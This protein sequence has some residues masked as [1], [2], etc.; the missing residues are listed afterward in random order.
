MSFFEQRIAHD[1]EAVAVAI[2][3]EPHALDRLAAL[4]RRAMPEC[5]HH[6][7]PARSQFG[8]DG[9]QDRRIERPLSIGI[10]TPIICVEPDKQRSRRVRGAEVELA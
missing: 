3:Q 9:L 10:Y 4:I 1:D 7:A 2:D 6:V 8:V 5:H